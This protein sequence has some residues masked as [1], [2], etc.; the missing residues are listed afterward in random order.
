M[1]YRQL[2]DKIKKRVANYYEH[3]YHQGRFFDENRVLSEVSVPLRD[4]SAY[5][6]SEKI[7]NLSLANIPIVYP[8]KTR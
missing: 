5:S 4:V 6:S 2:P 8:L 3:K 7:I 1:N